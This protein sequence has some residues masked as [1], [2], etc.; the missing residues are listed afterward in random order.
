MVKH[1]PEPH[2]KRELQGFQAR[3]NQGVLPFENSPGVSRWL[4]KRLRSA[5]GNRTPNLRITR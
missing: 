4:G 5:L 3:P 1:E 2:T